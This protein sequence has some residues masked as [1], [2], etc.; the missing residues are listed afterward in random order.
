MS[1]E[2]QQPRVPVD[3]RA[4]MDAADYRAR[5][6][7]ELAGHGLPPFRSKVSVRRSSGDIEDDWTLLGLNH[8]EGDPRVVALKQTEQGVIRKVI[9]LE[10]FSAAQPTPPASLEAASSS[11]F[12][13]K[14]SEL[15]RRQLDK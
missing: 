13:E 5:E 1:K 12:L 15:A 9:P 7:A 2:E 11:D 6:D 3:D 4:A 8:E 14:S 10:E